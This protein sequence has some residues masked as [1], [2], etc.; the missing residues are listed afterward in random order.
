MLGN[1]L[2]YG[3]T[4]EDFVL[5]NN[6]APSDTLSHFVWQETQ[7]KPQ[8]QGKNTGITEKYQLKF[9]YIIECNIFCQELFN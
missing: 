3:P 1:Y 9:H 2:R 8:A 5:E 7:V 4:A 6:D